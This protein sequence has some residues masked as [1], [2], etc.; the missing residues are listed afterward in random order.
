MALINR[1]VFGDSPF[2]ERVGV[3][4]NICS[5]ESPC[6][7]T[8]WVV[9]FVQIALALVLIFFGSCMGDVV[10]QKEGKLPELNVTYASDTVTAKAPP[11][12]TC[13]AA[14]MS[15]TPSGKKRTAFE[16]A[17]RSNPVFLSTV[18][19]MAPSY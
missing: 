17:L 2:Q 19:T 1:F 8:G 13:S 11:E 3:P 16:A 9:L 18:R 6:N 7:A 10:C 5:G 15:L 14:C 12:A 4:L